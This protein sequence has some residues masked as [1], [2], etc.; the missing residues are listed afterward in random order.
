MIVMDTFLCAVSLKQEGADTLFQL[1]QIS[2]A[3]GHGWV[4]E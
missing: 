3:A 4:S 1:G 2:G